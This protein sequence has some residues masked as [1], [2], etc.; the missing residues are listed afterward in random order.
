MLYNMNAMTDIFNP[1]KAEGHNITKEHMASFS[2]YDKDYLGRSGSFKLNL[3]K[4][5]KQKSGTKL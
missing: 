5:P 3:E 4:K 1:L 2:L